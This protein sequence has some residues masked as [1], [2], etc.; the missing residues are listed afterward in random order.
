MVEITFNDGEAP[1]PTLEV[2]AVIEATAETRRQPSLLAPLRV[3]NFRLL[4]IGEGIS[5]LGDQ[6]YMVALPWLV[7]QLTGSGLAVGTV[8][9]LAGIPRAVLM[10]VGGALT[11]RFS[12]RGLMFTSNALRIVLTGLLTALVLTRT[13]ELWMLYFLAFAF[14]VVDAF[15]LPAQ[16]AML[17][18]LIQKDDLDAGNAITQITG[19]LTNLVGPALAGLVIA[20]LTD[21]AARTALT[22]L[23]GTPGFATDILRVIARSNTGGMTAAFGF[24]TL[25]FV[26]ATLALWLMNSKHMVMPPVSADKPKNPEGV[27]ASIKEGLHIA[28]TDPAMRVTLI[29]VAGLNFLFNAPIGIGIPILANQRYSEGALAFGLM[30]AAFGLGALVGALMAGGL[31]RPKRFGVVVMLLMA[32]SGVGMGLLGIAA[33]LPVAIGISVSMGLAVGYVNVVMS[34]WLQKRTDPLVMGRVMS[35]VMLAAFG[36]QPISGILAGVLV[37]FSPVALFAGA[38]TCI[39]LLS[40]WGATTPIVRTME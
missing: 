5:L 2:P 24:D 1:S 4:W 18:S 28:W 27:W 10:L 26:V 39:V 34:A 29:L 31:P 7:L 20:T 38:G 37:D 33:T 12:P 19:Q 3:R 17:P 32:S 30:I 40:L 23:H 15:F 22:M 8:L 25:T 13:I 6:F 11:D 9:G 16:S 14:G 35:L 21:S 36:L